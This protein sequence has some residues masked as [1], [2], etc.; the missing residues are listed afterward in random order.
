VMRAHKQERV[1]PGAEKRVGASSDAYQRDVAARAALS[2]RD[3]IL[4]LFR[5]GAGQKQVAATRCHVATCHVSCFEIRTPPSK[6]RPASFQ[7]QTL[8]LPDPVCAAFS[9]S[10]APN[11]IRRRRARA[12]AQQV[13]TSKGVEIG[14]Q[15][16]C[17]NRP[18]GC[19]RISQSF[20]ARN[21]GAFSPR[22]QANPPFHPAFRGSMCESV[23]HTRAKHAGLF[24]L[25]CGLKE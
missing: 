20:A 8:F 18:P 6:Y 12:G 21:R 17:G 10:P 22:P 24:R 4:L 7:I 19:Q 2:A 11:T 9:P 16:P 5:P 25:M 23:C 14:Q 15:H 1:V 13:Q 3:A